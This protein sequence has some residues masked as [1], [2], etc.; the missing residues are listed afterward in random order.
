MPGTRPS[1]ARWLRTYRALE[2]GSWSDFLYKNQTPDD[3]F[4]HVPLPCHSIVFSSEV[5][6]SRIRLIKLVPS[7]RSRPAAD[8]E[9]LEERRHATGR[10]EGQLW[11][12]V[13]VRPE[14]VCAALIFQNRYLANKGME[15][16][17][18]EVIS[19]LVAEGVKTVDRLPEFKGQT[20]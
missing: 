9:Q 19:L 11:A 13:K 5:R 1:H 14:V 17:I 18:G 6:N 7:H 15:V 16:T 12:N 8:G 10:P 2:K 20:S 3:L 4:C